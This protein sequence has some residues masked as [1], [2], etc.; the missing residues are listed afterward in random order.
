MSFKPQEWATPAVGADGSVYVGS[1]R[2]RFDAFDRTGRL[3]WQVA[4]R[5]GISSEPL[6][7][8]RQGVVYFGADDGRLYAV[9]TATGKLRWTYTI[10]GV[11]RHRPA[12]SDGVLLFTSSENRIY[13]LDASTGK[14]RWQYDRERP[15]GFTIHG[16][17]GVLVAGGLAYTG[18][19]DGMVVALKPATGEVVWTR[20]V[21]GEDEASRF[22]DADA[23]PVMLGPLVVCAGYSTGVYA[24]SADTGAVQWQL[25]L[26]GV[27]ALAERSGR[28]VYATAPKVGIVAIDPRGHTIWRQA[29]PRGVPSAPVVARDY[30][31]V[32]STETG[33]YVASAATGELIERFSPGQG[34]SAAAGVGPRTLAVLSN[35]GHLYAFALR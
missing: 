23:T 8:E 1:S 6:L 14:W 24:L 13:A 3:R 21:A 33:I 22:V 34:V 19:A 16:F 27:Y 35:A 10:S 11:V 20:S 29:L 32:S 26:P 5:G 15:E 18:F 7:D 17:A 4:A 30:V 2:G 28:A 12:Y 25:D 9:A 31:L